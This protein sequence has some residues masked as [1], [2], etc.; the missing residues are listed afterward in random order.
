MLRQTRLSADWEWLRFEPVGEARTQMLA[1]PEV[2]N[3][4]SDKGSVLIKWN[5]VVH[6]GVVI[7]DLGDGNSGLSLDPVEPE[8]TQ[9]AKESD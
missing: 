7:P 5:P 2:I 9:K 4:T 1:E 8:Q 3:W 6:N